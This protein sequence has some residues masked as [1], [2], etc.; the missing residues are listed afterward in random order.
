MD[1]SNYP[2]DGD[3]VGV[4]VKDSRQPYVFRK[5]KSIMPAEFRFRLNHRSD[6]MSHG[7]Y[8]RRDAVCRSTWRYYIE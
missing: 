2:S 4:Y 3:T 1:S 8:I 6:S 7:I 5:R